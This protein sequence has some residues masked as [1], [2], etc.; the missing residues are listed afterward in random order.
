MKFSGILERSMG[1][2]TKLKMRRSRGGWE[3][4][5]YVYQLETKVRPSNDGILKYD[6]KMVKKK[7]V[8][9][10][11][12]TRGEAKNV[13]GLVHFVESGLRKAIF[14]TIAN[15]KPWEVPVAGNNGAIAD[16]VSNVLSGCGGLSKVQPENLQD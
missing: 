8:I 13:L 4:W 14:D 12:L 7:A 5:K 9:D 6:I 3:V 10:S 1:L 2:D 11:R 15:Y 16:T